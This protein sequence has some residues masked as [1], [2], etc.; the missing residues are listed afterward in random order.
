VAR[1]RT[2]RSNNQPIL[3]LGLYYLTVGLFLIGTAAPQGRVWGFNWWAYLPTVWQALLGLVAL[4]G[5]PVLWFL[6]GRLYHRESREG[7]DRP[8]EGFGY[9]AVP[10]VV[11]SAV[12]FLLFPGR[13]HFLGDGYQLLTRLADGL[14]SVKSWDVGA[15]WLNNLVFSLTSGDNQQ[16]A[17]TAYRLISVISGI[18]TFG[19]VAIAAGKLFEDRLRRV[20]FLV[21]VTTGGYSLMFFGYVE[22][23]A[24]LITMLALYA[25]LGLRALRGH[26]S[27]WWTLP[28]LAVATALHI[29]G[30][31]LL[32]SFGYLVLRST[33][34]A[35]RLASLPTKTKLIIAAVLLLLGLALYQYLHSSFRFF[36]FAFLPI[37][38][39]QFTVEGDYLLSAKHVIDTL[40]LLLLLLPGLLVL[41]AAIGMTVG[42]KFFAPAEH[43]FLL[44]MTL[45]TLAA[46][47]VFNPGIGMPRNW[48][49][50]SVVGVPLAFLCFYALLSQ[51]ANSV[52]PVLS[53][54]L[55]CL[56][57]LV[58][59][60]PRVASQVSPPVGI[61]HFKNYLELDKI[62]NRNAR[63]LLVDYYRVIGDETSASREQVLAEED[64]PESAFQKRGKQELR[65]GNVDQ[66]EAD[67]KRALELNPLFY[68]AYANL[69]SCRIARGQLDSALVL[70][71]IADGLN[72]YN[73]STISNIGTVYL[74]QNEIDKAMAS[75]QE[76]L[77]IDSTNQNSMVGLAS[78]YLKAGRPARS[79]AYVTKL[80]EQTDLGPEY[81]R[82]ATEAYLQAGY[83]EQARDAFEYAKEKGLPAKEIRALT[84]KYPQLLE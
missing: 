72:P 74:R 82:Q 73:A 35:R 29:F 43:R 84:G 59:L 60:A 18:L 45:S 79:L 24:L 40:N 23:Y 46:V 27:A 20:L 31:L 52:I 70:L 58:M 67:F 4:A 6:V 13:T 69:A 30:L 1:K 56:L 37:L 80:S 44:I 76:A 26:I 53:S 65:R 48:D 32:P 10:Y 54:A 3:C 22:N 11:L 75:F 14:G 51:R 16:R 62:R 2:S 63:S 50:F 47:H 57:A 41:A 28:V 55:A 34:P 21:G 33:P 5:G 78:C 8:S 66:A 15:S 38:P 77:R 17:L 12:L 36:T 49:L 61:A 25:F 81:F 7:S 19:V 71:Q 64:F 42:R 68:D 39:D 83:D 9:V